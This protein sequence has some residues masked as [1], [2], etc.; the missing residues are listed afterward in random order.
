M[1]QITQ[2]RRASVQI[3]VKHAGA[4][5][6]PPAT[7]SVTLNNQGYAGAAGSTSAVAGLT[8][9][10]LT[11]TPPVN[12]STLVYDSANHRYNVQL[13]DLDGGSF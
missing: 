3:A 10:N 4:T 6:V 12:N 9:V 7:G 13:L 11:S 2:K 1:P 5:F 8:D